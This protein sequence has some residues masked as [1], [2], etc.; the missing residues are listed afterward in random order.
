MLLC[1]IL[2]GMKEAEWER[3]RKRDA[4]GFCRRR[5]SIEMRQLTDDG[6]SSLPFQSCYHWFYQIAQL[7]SWLVILVYRRTGKPWRPT[8]PA[9][10]VPNLYALWKYLDSGGGMEA[11]DRGKKISGGMEDE[12]TQKGKKQIRMKV[13]RRVGARVAGSPW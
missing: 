8:T 7:R 1:T 5:W 12:G 13:W 9:F 10:N 4:G 6:G 3:W 2:E 11:E